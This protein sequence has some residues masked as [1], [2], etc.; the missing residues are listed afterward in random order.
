VLLDDD[1]TAMEA[2]AHIVGTSIAQGAN[3]SIRSPY[4]PE[5]LGIL[6]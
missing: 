1:E 4:Q 5:E 6:S 3:V 2:F